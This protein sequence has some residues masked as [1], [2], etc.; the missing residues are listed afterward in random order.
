[1]LPNP[2]KLISYRHAAAEDFVNRLMHLRE[3]LVLD[4]QLEMARVTLDVLGRTIFSDGLER[5][6]DEIAFAVSRIVA[7]VG[8]LD[9]FDILDFPEWIPRLGKL[10][11]RR[12]QAFFSSL[13]ESLIARR[14]RL[15]ARNK[16]SA[17][18]DILTLLLEAQDPQTGA[19]LILLCHKR[20]RVAGRRGVD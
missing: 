14:K 6:F 18:R 3:G 13:V 7:T 11:G 20:N 1:M 5:D 16:A 2:A 19:G 9:P 17:P 10:G 4:V 15:L 8:R 12:A